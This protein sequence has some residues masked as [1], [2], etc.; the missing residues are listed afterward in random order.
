M[1]YRNTGK[2]LIDVFAAAV[3]LVI[4]SPVIFITVLLL[5]IT[6]HRPV[7]FIQKRPGLNEKVFGLIKLRTMTNK[8][9]SSGDLFPD[10]ER[11]TATGK[12]IRQLSID[13]LPQLLNVIK[14][15][16]SI[17]GPRPLLTE[18]LPL[19]NETQKKR[20]QVKPGI[21]G[22]AQVNGRNAVSWEKKFEMD[23]WYVQNVSFLLDLK[24]IF[25]T[26]QKV[27]AAKGINQEGQ[28]TAEKFKGNHH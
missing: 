17:V 27:F 28:A 16:M 19:Y 2:R 23:V 24:I 12:L 25:L 8:T 26:M 18:Y 7:F 5:F 11:L 20:H 14:G 3:L 9:N 15:D 10:N 6:G 1:I 22:W 13:E 21:T 4:V